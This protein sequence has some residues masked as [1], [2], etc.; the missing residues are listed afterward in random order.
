ML[1]HI[2]M[3]IGDHFS[4]EICE[5]HEI[6]RMNVVAEYWDKIIYRII[7][8]PNNYTLFLLGKNLNGIIKILFL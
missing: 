6:K 4:G 2:A 5:I 3:K 1:S 8:E 7:I